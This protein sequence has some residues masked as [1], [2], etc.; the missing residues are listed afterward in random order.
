MQNNGTGFLE[1]K[2][3]DAL[4]MQSQASSDT[5]V[6]G[7]TGFSCSIDIAD[8]LALHV[9]MLAIQRSLNHTIANCLSDNVFSRLLAT[10]MQANANIAERNA[11]VRQRHHADTRLDDVL[12]QTQ[13]QRVGAIAA[14]RLGVIGNSRLKVFQIAHADSLHQEEVRVEG[15]LERRLAE[16]GAV[17]NVAHE[18]LDNEQKLGGSLGEANGTRARRGLTRRCSE[19]LVGFGVAQLDSADAAEVVKESGDLVVNSV[20]GELGV[21]DEEIGLVDVRSQQIAAQQQHNDGCLRVDILAQDGG[22]Q[23]S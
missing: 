23:S 2:Y 7:L 15:V 1:G 22:T 11:R 16:G 18:Q 4:V 10:E 17:G 21:R 9:S 8:L 6:K 3:L 20:L 19:V 5:V 14:E 13:N 12:A